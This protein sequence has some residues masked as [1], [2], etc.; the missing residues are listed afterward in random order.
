VELTEAVHLVDVARGHG[1][2]DHLRH[3]EVHPDEHEER[4][5]RDQEAG[6]PGLHHQVA[7]EEADRK[8]ERQGQG[9]SHPEVDAVLVAEDRVDQSGRGHHDTGGEVELAADHQHP[10]TDGHDADRRALVEHRGQRVGGP[11]G[12][13]NDQEEDPDDDRGHQGADLGTG[14][15]PVEGRQLDSVRS[16]RGRADRGFL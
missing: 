8:G 16:L 3:P 5:Q 2:G 10:H 9:R 11:E 6:D 13:S 4:P 15:Y 7:V 12:R 1:P 14:Q